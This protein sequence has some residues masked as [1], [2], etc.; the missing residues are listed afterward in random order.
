MYSDEDEDEEHQPEKAFKHYEPIHLVPDE[1]NKSTYLLL[2]FF[3]NLRSRCRQQ[4]LFSDRSKKK[5]E[6]LQSRCRS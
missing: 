4:P 3:G 5:K 2:V 1:V 6:Y